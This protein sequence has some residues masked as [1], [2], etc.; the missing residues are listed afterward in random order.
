MSWKVV[1]ILLGLLVVL[2]VSNVIFLNVYV[3]KILPSQLERTIALTS[4][5]SENTTDSEDC[6][7]ACKI[8]LQEEIEELRQSLIATGTSKLAVKPTSTPA[9][10]PTPSPTPIRSI[11]T[12]VP[13]G[14]GKTSL[15]QW[16]DL[17]G[18]EGYINT[19][20]YPPITNVYF[21]VALRIPTKNG[22]VS[23]R[24]YN[25]TDNHPVWNSEVSTE[26]ETSTFIGSRSLQ[27]DPGN[28]L[29]RVQLKTTLR[30]ESILDFSRIKIITSL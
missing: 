25:V 20:S 21:E 6:G 15:D 17:K 30:Y 27:L 4:M 19:E 22:K 11:E 24:L 29:Y 9:V 13:L 14:G 8:Y 18:I 23:A 28:K 2:C 16:E 3:F 12:Y 26:N 1:K 7:P 10:T 5:A